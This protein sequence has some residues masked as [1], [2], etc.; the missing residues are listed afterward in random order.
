MAMQI[1]HINYILAL[2]VIILAFPGK[3]LC[4]E[5][6]PSVSVN[7]LNRNVVISWLNDYKKPISNILIQRSY[8]S[9]K[10]FTTIGSV[11]T[12]QNLENGYPDRLPPYD[13]MYYRVMINF[14]GGEYVIG[15]SSRAYPE[16]IILPSID[17]TKIPEKTLP[18]EGETNSTL[19]EKEQE[20][21]EEQLVLNKEKVSVDKKNRKDS[22]KI[23]GLQERK[24]NAI[25]NTEPIHIIET[26]F[27]SSRVYTNKQNV[28]IITIQQANTKK[29]SLKIFDE[30]QKLA[31]ELKRISDDY[32]MLEKSN[33][34][35]SGWFSFEIYEEGKLYEKNKFFISKDK[36]K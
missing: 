15:P 33:F 6:L 25:Q 16:K 1:K 24:L 21:H 27:P 3:I 10:N 36:V 13:R 18:M 12:P 32:L 22:M 34:F 35:H 9:S 8:D 26:T 20:D 2:M 29:Y 30:N 11:L 7:A 31:F 23:V 5:T 14:E 19:K 28:V 17:I 4:Q